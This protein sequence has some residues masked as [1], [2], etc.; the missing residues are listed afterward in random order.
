MTGIRCESV[1]SAGSVCII[2]VFSAII[3]ERNGIVGIK[4]SGLTAHII[5]EEKIGG[6]SLGTTEMYVG[7][8]WA[9]GV[10]IDGHIIEG[11]LNLMRW[12][13]PGGI[14]RAR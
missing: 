2:V 5:V 6:K 12:V 7:K 10:I 11:I 1:Y 3:V 14:G 13:K 9:G 4:I 8:V